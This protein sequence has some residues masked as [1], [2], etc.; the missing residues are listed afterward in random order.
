MTFLILSV[1]DG[2]SYQRNMVKVSNVLLI[3]QPAPYRKIIIRQLGMSRMT[4]ITRSWMMPNSSCM[5]FFCSAGS[6]FHS[7]RLTGFMRNKGRFFRWT[8]LCISI[9]AKIWKSV[10]KANCTTVTCPEVINVKI[11]VNVYYFDM[12]FWFILARFLWVHEDM[13]PKCSFNKFTQLLEW[14]F[15]PNQT[16]IS[17][18]SHPVYPFLLHINVCV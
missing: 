17:E 1:T 16:F 5:A 18:L 13:L 4:C 11:P 9:I 14:L 15:H 8:G 6:F 7:L 3:R 12:L 10:K 2:K